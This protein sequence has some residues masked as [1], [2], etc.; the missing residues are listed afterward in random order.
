M[1]LFDKYLSDMKAF[2]GF[3]SL[4]V[5]VLSKHTCCTWPTGR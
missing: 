2:V 1:N 4:S 3:F 5:N